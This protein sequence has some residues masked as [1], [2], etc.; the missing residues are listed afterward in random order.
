MQLGGRGSSVHSLSRRVRQLAAYWIPLHSPV[1]PF[2][3]HPVRLR[4]PS[5]TDWTLL[6]Y[7]TQQLLFP[8]DQSFK[9]T[10]VS[11]SFLSVSFPQIRRTQHAPG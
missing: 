5:H 1:L 10:Y 3:S 7:S 8:K 11:A 2:T 9:L 6:M 4:A